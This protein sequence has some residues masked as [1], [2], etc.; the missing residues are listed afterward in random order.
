MMERDV[1]LQSAREARNGSRSSRASAARQ[2]TRV[3]IV[4]TGH[5]GS[6]VAYALLIS[7]TVAEIVLIDRDKKRAEGHVH[8]LRDAALFSH[9]TRIVAGDFSDCG[10]A[11]V[12][13]ITASAHQTPGVKSRFDGLN[14]SS[15][16]LRD[17]V[18]EIARYDPR[19][20]LLIASNPVDVLT[21]AALKWSG[22]PASAL[23]AREPVWTRPGFVDGL[24]NGTACPRTTYMPM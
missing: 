17:I 13:V 20:I 6:T 14:E 15:S 16:I 18:R 11:D 8:D 5:V 12:I 2:V 19:G 1:L 21:Y 9:T 4:G 24:A 10:A 22:L 23:S 3:V 7:G